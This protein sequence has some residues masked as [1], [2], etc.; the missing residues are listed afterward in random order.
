MSHRPPLP[1]P[2]GATGT[3]RL[4]AVLGAGKARPLAP[5]GV[6]FDIFDTAVKGAGFQTGVYV[7]A[8][9]PQ[10]VAHF[11]FGR[12]VPPGRRT[13]FG[14]PKSSTFRTGA[15]GTAAKYHGKWVSLGGGS[16]SK[17]K[18]PLDGAL[19]EVSDE[20][21]FAQHAPGRVTSS[22][23]YVPWKSRGKPPTNERLRLLVADQPN[24]NAKRYMFCFE[25]KYAD[26]IR[27]FPKVDDLQDMRGGQAMVTASH[28]EIDSCASF[29]VEQILHYQK[30]AVTAN[31][32]NY[33]TGYTLRTL[34]GPVFEA[35]RTELRKT[36]HA[37]LVAYYALQGALIKSLIQKDQNARTP[38]GK[39]DRVM[40][41]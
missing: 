10:G 9:D 20:A 36:N 2:P 8:V 24:P 25:M 6:A 11:G 31:R 4:S 18:H 7:Y 41:K 32:D 26:F 14:A 39:R 34:V 3:A 27:L 23:V 40:Y 13:P 29:T 21:F 19:I 12:K 16:D 30:A 15:A 1:P 5:V 28:G 35:L 37:K 33:F 17:S 38:N 22:D